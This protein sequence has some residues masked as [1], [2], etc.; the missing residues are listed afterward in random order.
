[1]KSLN[2]KHTALWSLIGLATFKTLQ[3]LWLHQQRPQRRAQLKGQVVVITGASSGIGSALAEVLAAAGCHLMLAA[4]RHDQLAELARRL[5]EQYQVPV[6]YQRTDVQAPEDLQALIAATENQL[7]PVDILINNAGI[8]SY[9]FFHQDSLSEMRRVF[10][11]NYWGVVHG[12]QAVLPGMQARRR[13]LIVNVS[14]VA[15][16]MAQPGIG[17][18]SA[19]KHALNGLSNALRMELAPYGI[20]VLLICPTSTQTDIVQAA[21]HKPAVRFN[22]ESYLGMSAQRVAQDTLKAILDRKNEHVFGWVEKVALAARPLA[23]YAFDG[24]L[25]RLAGFVFRDVESNL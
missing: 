1:M 13:G 3:P 11:V 2:L 8:A 22:P 20:R 4:R 12:I 7:G 5:S 18:Y 25:R 14:S 17:N 15:G 19:S 6:K 10:E 24:I 16:K 9:A 21:S 23:P